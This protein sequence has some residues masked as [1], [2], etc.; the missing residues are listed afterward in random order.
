MAGIPKL[1]AFATS[2]GSK[3]GAWWYGVAFDRHR[4][5]GTGQP[6]FAVVG[7]RDA[8]VYQINTLDSHVQAQSH[9]RGQLQPPSAPSRPLSVEILHWFESSNVSVS[10]E[11]HTL[12]PPGLEPTCQPAIQS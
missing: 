3:E 1:A 12:F 4:L 7:G 11:M 5:T 2:D 10:P 8:I 9:G 6:V